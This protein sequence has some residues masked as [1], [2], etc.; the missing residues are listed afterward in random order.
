MWIHLCH[1]SDIVFCVQQHDSYT[2]GPTLAS[3]KSR[4]VLEMWRASVGLLFVLRVLKFSFLLRL[5]F[6]LY[7]PLSMYR[8]AV[9]ILRTDHVFCHV[10]PCPLVNNTS[11]L[12]QSVLSTV[13]L[14]AACFLEAMLPVYQTTRHHI[15][16]AVT[17]TCTSKS[18]TQ[19]FVQFK[20]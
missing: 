20:V 13:Y 10:T 8:T 14:E 1:R 11:L 5:I 12:T 15:R 7:R 19:H 4:F 2:G 16:E 9:N 18:L 17:S 6:C 3:A